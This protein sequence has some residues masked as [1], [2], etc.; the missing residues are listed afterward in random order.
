MAVESFHI[1][2]IILIHQIKNT[3]ERIIKVKQVGTKLD[4]EIIKE[5]DTSFLELNLSIK[6]KQ[7]SIELKSTFDK[8]FSLTQRE[9][10]EQYIPEKLELLQSSLENTFNRITLIHKTLNERATI[11]LDINFISRDNIISLEKHVII[12]D[13]ARAKNKNIFAL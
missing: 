1:I 6:A 11:D 5:S 3:L 13:K 9:F 12:E 4:L 10:I 8:E 2:Q 7:I